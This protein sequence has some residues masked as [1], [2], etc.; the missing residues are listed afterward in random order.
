MEEVL[1]LLSDSLEDCDNRA[2]KNGLIWYDF[3]PSY[4]QE[5]TPAGWDYYTVF[6]TKYGL[7]MGAL[8]LEKTSPIDA[9]RYVPR[10]DTPAGVMDAALFECR[11]IAFIRHSPQEAP[12]TELA[13]AE[14]TSEAAS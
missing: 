10:I 8:Y 3:A 1:K 9:P 4:S 12:A 11:K 5:E 7:L 14:P 2:V 13:P 6:E